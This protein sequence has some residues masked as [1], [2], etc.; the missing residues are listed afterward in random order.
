ML[1]IFSS[2]LL[3]LMSSVVKLHSKSKIKLKIILYI[4]ILTILNVIILFYKTII[5][6]LKNKKLFKNNINLI[7]FYTFFLHYYY[8]KNY[9][10]KLI[11]N[12]HHIIACYYF[13]VYF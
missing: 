2:I 13:K 12:F 10:I 5:E 7:I 8:L 1:S 6:C 3:M 9:L 4:Y 11:T